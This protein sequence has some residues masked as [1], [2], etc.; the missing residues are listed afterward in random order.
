MLIHYLNDRKSWLAFFL[1]SLLAADSLIW[2]DPGIGVKVSSVIYMN[3]LLLLALSLFI[4]WRYR[5]ETKFAR[6][7]KNLAKE[8]VVDWIEALPEADFQ[9]DEVTIEVLQQAGRSFSASM[10]AIRR[11]HLVQG[12]Y[13]AAWVHEAKAPL[14]AMKLVVDANRDNAAMRKI[15]AEWLRLYLLIDQ[16]LYISRLPALESDYVLEETPL[17]AI[18]T[19]EAR[20]LMSWCREKNLAI[21]MDGL[22]QMV[23]TDKKWSRFILRQVLSNAVKY[24]PEGAM[25]EIAAHVD[26][27]GHTILSITDEG[28]G[29]EVHELPRIFDKGYTGGTGRLLN[30]ATGLGLYLAKTVADKI[31]VG[32]TARSQ[33]G[34]GTTIEL[35]FSHEN[36]FDA[37]RK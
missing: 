31:G 36:D 26:E 24:S 32:L 4:Y 20:E 15:E 19:G 10:N 14:T 35:V 30:A 13:M 9:Q 12:D 6:Q 23:V 37:I 5:K 34:E 25:I 11:D 8:P 17:R 27:A 28:P 2:L 16:Q 1:L 29:I 3:V 7:L 22:D 33:K 21:D 18:V